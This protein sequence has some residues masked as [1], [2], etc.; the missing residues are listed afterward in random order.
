MLAEHPPGGWAPGW[1]SARAGPFEAWSDRFQ[2][3]TCQCRD[4]RAAGFTGRSAVQYDFLGLVDEVAL[5]VLHADL[6]QHRHG[7]RIFDA[8]GHGL[9]MVLARGLHQQAHP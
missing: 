7:V 1:T 6:P 4:G 3:T 5:D 9:D 2:L 8:L